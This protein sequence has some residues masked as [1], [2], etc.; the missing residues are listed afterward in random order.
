MTKEATISTQS[1][2]IPVPS[3]KPRGVK[4]LEVR[5]LGSPQHR[6]HDGDM[7]GT[8][9]LGSDKPRAAHNPCT[10]RQNA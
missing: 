4:G 6:N 3:R 2:R 5:T 10:S 9:T 7:M 1:Q 8:A